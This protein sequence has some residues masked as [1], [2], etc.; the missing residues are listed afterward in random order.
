M[1]K[2]TLMDNRLCGS[3]DDPDCGSPGFAQGIDVGTDLSDDAACTLLADQESGWASLAPQSAR[4]AI[5]R[6]A[7]RWLEMQGGERDAARQRF[8]RWQSL[9]SGRA[10]SNPAEL[11]GF[12]RT[13]R[14][15]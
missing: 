3:A 7:E 15:S 12:S 9:G 8:S 1:N 4:R 10:R 2:H 5:A 13:C 11:L 6:G 14:Q